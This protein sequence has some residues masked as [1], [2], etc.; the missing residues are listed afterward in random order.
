MKI[1]LTEQDIAKM[2]KKAINGL[3]YESRIDTVNLSPKN[4]IKVN[5]TTAIFKTNS[6]HVNNRK[7][8]RNVSM[9]DVINS[10]LLAE[11]EL[12]MKYENL[13]KKYGLRNRLEIVNKDVIGKNNE[14]DPY[15]GCL[16]VQLKFYDRA[17]IT[18]ETNIGQLSGTNFKRIITIVTVGYWTGESTV[19]IKDPEVSVRLGK[20]NQVYL[21]ALQR[22]RVMGIERTPNNIHGDE[23]AVT[24]TKKKYGADYVS[25]NKKLT[26]R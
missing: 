24:A 26:N 12:A 17:D 22:Q 15:L 23:I 2:V 9:D 1:L 7:D 19:Q 8:E 14:S 16:Y 11:D 6:D 4:L 5:G 20:D 3:L 21:D 13:K 25:E 10:I 18:D